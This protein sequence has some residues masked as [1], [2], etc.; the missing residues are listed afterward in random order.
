MAKGKK[1]AKKT[2]RQ[3]LFRQCSWCKK[4]LIKAGDGIKHEREYFCGQTCLSEWQ[5]RN[6]IVRKELEGQK[7]VVQGSGITVVAIGP[8]TIE[9]RP[10]PVS[11]VD[12]VKGLT[13]AEF[14]NGRSDA[15][16]EQLALQ[17][18]TVRTQRRMQRVYFAAL[19]ALSVLLVLFA[20]L[21]VRQT[22]RFNAAVKTKS[23]Q[24]KT[25]A[26][27]HATQIDSLKSRTVELDTSQLAVGYPGDRTTQATP[28]LSVLGTGRD[29]LELTLVVNN[30][31]AAHK[32]VRASKFFFHN[33]RL[34]TGENLILLKG[35]DEENK[36]YEKKLTVYYYRDKQRRRAADFVEGTP[37][38]L[39]K[40]IDYEK[41]QNFVP[42]DYPRGLNFTRGSE[43]RK[44]A[45]L[46]FDGGAHAVEA[47]YI[48]DT[49]KNRGVLATFFL[50]GTFI[51][52]FPALVHR[53]AA[54]GHVLG[55]H[56]DRHS[57]LTT[58]ETDG[59]QNT[60]PQVTRE[61]LVGQLHAV[62]QKYKRLGI[63]IPRLWRAPY[64]EQNRT[65]NAWAE[66]AGYRHIGWT[67]GTSWR[68]NLDTNDWIVHPGDRGY[69]SPDQ[70]IEKITH[71]GVGTAYGLNGGI[72]LMHIGT[73]RQ[74]QKMYTR[75]GAL[76]DTLRASGYELVTIND[77][78]KDYTWE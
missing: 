9:E 10:Q 44:W 39:G 14:L 45:A 31:V 12:L 35:V 51:D 75:L 57:H 76:I 50:A 54:E 16:I 67:M 21:N 53:I 3:G 69:F 7:S 25:L 40:A 41:P 11:R 52:K 36:I 49:L 55:N 74:G 66:S 71:F 38:L 24:V 68:T 46:T 28:F 63:D 70:V 61:F 32:K 33:I 4:H 22:R 19:G 62:E 42:N 30:T 26:Q 58:L 15:E 48:L 37:V 17:L 64:G 27:R 78:T 43:T 6:T 73:I 23:V 72:I 1:S 2:G 77:M 29:G 8:A 5:T 56:T 34:D 13:V 60:L 47:A 18:G 65:I 59:L 20:V